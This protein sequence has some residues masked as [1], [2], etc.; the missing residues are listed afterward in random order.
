MQRE[1]FFDIDL[2]Q[3]TKERLHEEVEK[4]RK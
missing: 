3:K 2:V 4:F 1:R